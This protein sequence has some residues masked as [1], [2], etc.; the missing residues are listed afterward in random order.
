MLEKETKELVRDLKNV[1]LSK[2]NYILKE[3]EKQKEENKAKVQEYQNSLAS[4]Q[5]EYNVYSQYAK[6]LEDD[7]AYAQQVGEDTTDIQAQIITNNQMLASLQQQ[8]TYY[9]QMI[10]ALQS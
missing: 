5:N 3:E 6:S 4:A 2:T 7:L 1:P 10:S 9:E 8:I